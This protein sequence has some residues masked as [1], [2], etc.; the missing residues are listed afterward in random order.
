MELEGKPGRRPEAPAGC[1][2]SWVG[3]LASFRAGGGRD[4]TWAPQVH[5]A[6]SRHKGP[7]LDTGFVGL[8]PHPLLMGSSPRD[9][10][11]HTL[12]LAGAPAAQPISTASLKLLMPMFPKPHLTKG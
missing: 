3:A 11:H 6:H 2:G 5:L 9:I 1:E 10:P 4:S 8:A 7:P 12:N